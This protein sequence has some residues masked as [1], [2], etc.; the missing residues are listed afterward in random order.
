[1]ATNFAKKNS[2]IVNRM[3]EEGHCI[4]LHSFEHKNALFQGKSYTSYDF[5]Q[6]AKTM[7]ELGFD[8][9][10]YRPPWRHYKIF[11]NYEVKNIT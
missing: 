2:I 10:Y 3:K 4:A 8:V 9:K 7:K 11:T 5:E 1:M 6:S